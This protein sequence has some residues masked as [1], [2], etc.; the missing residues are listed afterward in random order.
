MGSERCAILLKSGQ[1]GELYKQQLIRL[2]QAIAEKQ[3]EWATGHEKLIFHLDNA[4]PH[5]TA[6]KLFGK[7]RMGYCTSPAL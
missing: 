2:K 3:S 6:Q 5:V 7:C 1:T 4:R